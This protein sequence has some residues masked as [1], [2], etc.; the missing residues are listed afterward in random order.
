M[1]PARDAS[2][3]LPPWTLPRQALVRSGGGWIVLS[4][5][6]APELWM[7]GRA[8]L[9]CH[10]FTGNRIETR[11]LFVRFARYL[12]A[13]GLPAAALDYRGNGESEGEFEEMAFST[14]VEDVQSALGHLRARAERGVEPRLALVGYSLGGMVAALTAGERPAGLA[15]VALWNAVA[16]SQNLLKSSLG[17]PVREALE[18][19]PFPVAINGWRLGRR[20]LEEA[21]ECDPAAALA[22]SGC[23]T[24]I[25]QAQ[26][27]SVVP[28]VNAERYRSA[29]E[30]AGGPV[31]MEILARGG[32]AFIDPPAERRLFARTREF[33]LLALD[34][35]GAQPADST[36]NLNF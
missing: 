18:S 1:P 13:G 16:D 2:P 29:M 3:S 19:F 26:D 30:A 33:L 27:D 21:L 20:F 15:G 35:V 10:G 22:R 8:A 24:L 31:E 17:R 4:L 7:R 28:L 34:A 11:R 12:V 25:L 5:Y 14:L 32:H 23:K 6:G 9:L 36:D